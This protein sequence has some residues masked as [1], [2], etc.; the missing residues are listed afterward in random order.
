MKKFNEEE[1]D[2]I[3]YCKH[4]NQKFKEDYNGRKTSL[5]EKVDKYKLQRIINDFK[6]NNINEETQENLK[7]IM[8]I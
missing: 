1:F 3:K 6:Q 2:K 5:I 7:N 4:C 8:K